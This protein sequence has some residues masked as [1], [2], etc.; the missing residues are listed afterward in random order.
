MVAVVAVA[1][2]LAVSPPV[3]AGVPAVRGAAES[4]SRLLT[5]P[6]PLPKLD[7]REV[8]PPGLVQVVVE[9]FL[10]DQ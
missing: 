10:S 1:L 6:P 9:L 8:S 4:V 2:A 3:L 5:R 7:A